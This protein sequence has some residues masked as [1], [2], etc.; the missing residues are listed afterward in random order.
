[1]EENLENKRIRENKRSK[2]RNSNTTE[3]NDMNSHN[4]DDGNKID[5]DS[6]II[7]HHQGVTITR[8]L[9]LKLQN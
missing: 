3:S 2:T 4:C 6:I 1:M 5:S 7:K 8:V 9:K